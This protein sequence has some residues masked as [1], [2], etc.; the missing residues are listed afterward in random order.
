MKEFFFTASMIMLFHTNIAFADNKINLKERWDTYNDPSRLESYVDDELFTYAFHELPLS[1]NLRSSPWSGGYWPSYQGGISYRW[2]MPAENDIYRYGYELLSDAD[3]GQADLTN[4]SPSEK[5]DIILR[6]YTFPHT[7]SE[8]ARTNVLKTVPWSSE[9][10][11]GYSIPY[12]FGLCHA[13]AP[14]T[15][16]FKQPKPVIVRN[17]DGIIVPFGS[18]DI[19]ALLA[20]FLDNNYGLTKLA[21]KRCNFE[22]DDLLERYRTGQISREEY[23][24]ELSSCSDINAGAFH[25]ALANQIGILGKSFLADI[26]RMPEV[27]NQPI[28]KY[29]THIVE[30]HEGTRDNS[31][32]GTVRVIKVKTTMYYTPEISYSWNIPSSYPET[33]KEYT[34]WLELDRNGSIIGGEW[35]NENSDRPDFIWKQKTPEFVGDYRIIKQLYDISVGNEYQPNK[36]YNAF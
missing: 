27:W 14:A 4:L 25:I 32:P 33:S 24:E 1:G 18:S 28:Y 20:Y 17:S 5:L 10:E 7:R 31:A 3:I 19:K 29:Q 22:I 34:Y 6:K 35:E 16:A 23:L 2:S 30:A 15:I 26:S 21:G 8:R 11:P 12:W 9:Y 36:I 13:W